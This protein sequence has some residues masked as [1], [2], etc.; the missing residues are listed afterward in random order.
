MAFKSKSESVP[1]CI[2]FAV[3]LELYM[4]VYSVYTIKQEVLFNGSK[5]I[6]TGLGQAKAG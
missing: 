1:N 6:R 3:G 4:D 5:H 2:M